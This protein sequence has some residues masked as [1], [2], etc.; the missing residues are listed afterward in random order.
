MKKTSFKKC[1]HVICIYK[2]DI[3]IVDIEFNLFFRFLFP[4]IFLFF[5]WACVCTSSVQFTKTNID[6][7]ET[8]KNE[9]SE[10]KASYRS[11]TPNNLTKS[12]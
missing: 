6:I 1:L 11:S 12:E 4:D 7:T 10:Y 3:Y 9:P 2:V 5:A 8:E